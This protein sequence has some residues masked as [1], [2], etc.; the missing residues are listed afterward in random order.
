MYYFQNHNNILILIIII[1]III[2]PDA[3]TRVVEGEGL[4]Q[5]GYWDYEFESR[6]GMIVVSVVG[7]Q[8]EVSA[9]V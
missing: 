6:R 7:C 3:S 4:R 8:E 5:L 2:I 9:S 1:I